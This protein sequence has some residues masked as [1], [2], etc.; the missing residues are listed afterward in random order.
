MGIRKHG[1]LIFKAIIFL[2]LLGIMFCSVNQTLIN[3]YLYSAHGVL[4]EKQ[5][6]FYEM[7]RDSVDVLFLGS[8]HAGASFNPQDLYNEYN[9]T[10]YNLGSHSQSLWLSY[11]WLKETLHYQSPQ[12]VVLDCYELWIDE[13]ATEVRAREN[14]DNMRLGTVKIEAVDTVCTFD[15]SQS[16]LSYLLTNIRYHERWS[17]LNETD[18]NWKEDICPPSKLKG[19][20][21]YIGQCGYESYVPLEVQNSEIEEFLPETK[22]YLDKI[23]ELCR[24]NNIQLILV[25][26][27]TLFMTVERHNAVAE[28]ADANDLLFFDFN[29]MSLYEQI[30]FYYSTDMYDNSTTGN[31]SAHANPSGARKMTYFIGDILLNNC[32]VTPRQDWQWEETRAFNEHIWKN[33]QLHNETDPKKYLSMLKDDSYTIFITVKDDA[34]RSLNQSLQEAL[35]DLGLTADW[36]DAFHDSY[37][38]VIENGQVVTEKMSDKKLEHSGS[39]RDGVVIYSLISAGGNSGNDCSITI[40]YSE[41]AKRKRGLNIVVY[42]NELK[43]VVD[44]VCFDTYAEELT[45]SR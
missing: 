30:G 3:K 2:C 5:Y 4:T 17:E 45:A 34:A 39:F 32:G 12:V 20:Y 23:V 13:T 33:F 25:K 24:E 14:L 38:A 42:D 40:N 7:E 37:Y 9:I 29:E 26:T 28:Y 35:S 22:D 16:V 27:P 11:Y 21:L 44:S 19:F 43:C 41:K 36:S 10:S 31:K 1:K 15:E 8:S 18:F 6:N